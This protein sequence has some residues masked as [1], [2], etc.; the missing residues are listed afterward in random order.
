MSAQYA[1]DWDELIW[2]VISLD[3]REHADCQGW[4]REA[5]CIV[6]ACG[7]LLYTYT[8]LVPAGGVL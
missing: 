3:H 4:W 8:N 7:V 2:D 1:E 5:G 6:C